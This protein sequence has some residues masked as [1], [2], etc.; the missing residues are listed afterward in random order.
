MKDKNNRLRHCPECYKI[1]RSGK[2]DDRY[3]F[4]VCP[5]GKEMWD[6]SINGD[7][8]WNSVNVKDVLYPEGFELPEKIPYPEETE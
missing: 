5:E 1:K 8:P 2:N 7:D 3:F 6:Y 4:E